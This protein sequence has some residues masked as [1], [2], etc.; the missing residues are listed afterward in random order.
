MA[1]LSVSLLQ[2]AVGWAN[3]KNGENKGVFWRQTVTCKNTHYKLVLFH[4]LKWA[5]QNWWMLV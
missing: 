5:R 1:Y 2:W 3:P 4:L